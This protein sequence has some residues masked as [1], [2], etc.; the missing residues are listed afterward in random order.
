MGT[1]LLLEAHDVWFFRT[2]RPFGGTQAT[3]SE[4]EPFV[5]PPPGVVFGAVRTALGG[6]HGVDWAAYR[7]AWANGNEPPAGWLKRLGPPRPRSGAAWPADSV[8]LNGVLPVRREHSVENL[9][10]PLPSFVLQ[11]ENDAIQSALP[12]RDRAGRSSLGNLWPVLPPDDFEGE[13]KKLYVTEP[14]F[15]ELLR[16][17][18]LGSILDH[19]KVTLADLAETEARVGIARDIGTRTVR[20][21]HLYMLETQ[22]WRSRVGYKSVNAATYGLA[23]LVENVS[24]A[25]LGSRLAL[26]LGGEGRIAW[27][28][29]APLERWLDTREVAEA[30]TEAA[31][32][33][34][35]L[36]TPAEMAAGWRPSWVVPDGDSWVARLDGVDAGRLVGLVADAPLLL[37]GWDLAN[38]CPKPV[39]RLMPVGTTWFFQ[40]PAQREAAVAAATAL[41]GTCVADVEAYAGF[42]LAFVGAW[43]AN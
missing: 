37:S 23:A 7:T 4:G 40:L 8:R 2:S 16:T 32:W 3:A 9:L 30:I 31:G 42:G 10:F 14:V 15:A 19:E 29:T 33:W 12:Q 21:G 24:A 38:E 43:K 34:L 6:R 36:A 22:R 35:T 28:T 39:R 18:T 41:Q 27:G 11:D 20:Q 17:G 26:P 25:E 13:S 5:L 1:R